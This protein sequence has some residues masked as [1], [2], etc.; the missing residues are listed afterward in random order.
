MA[1]NRLVHVFHSFLC[2]WLRYK[3]QIQYKYSITLYKF[4]LTIMCPK[5]VHNVDFWVC[6]HEKEAMLQI[7]KYGTKNTTEM[8]IYLA[9]QCP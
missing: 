6:R 7:L 2:S 8:G 5:T 4:V 1:I 9:M 3:L